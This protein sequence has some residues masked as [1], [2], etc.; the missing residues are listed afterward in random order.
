[1]CFILISKKRYMELREVK[2]YVQ[3][4]TVEAHIDLLT[5]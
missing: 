2:K 1:M 5:S 3:E 4:I